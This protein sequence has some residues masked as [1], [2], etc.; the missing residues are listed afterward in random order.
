MGADAVTGASTGA[1][2]HPG[3]DDGDPHGGVDVRT[4]DG[5]TAVRFWGSVDL[6]VR[7]GG[8]AGLGELLGSAG[9]VTVDCRD[10]AFMDSTGLSVLVRVV[11][12]ATGAGR[13]VR[14]L[15]ASPQVADLLRFAGVDEWMAA[16]G[17]VADA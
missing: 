1:F 2:G 10:V 15:G 8:T 7:L 12:D 3:D 5:V 11:R 6:S 14:F 9:P 4:D 13:P 16:L 17:V